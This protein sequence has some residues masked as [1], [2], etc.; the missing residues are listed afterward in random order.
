MHKEITT[1]KHILQ[2]MMGEIIEGKD[3]DIH[4]VLF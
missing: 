3:A 4:L 1:W 2:R